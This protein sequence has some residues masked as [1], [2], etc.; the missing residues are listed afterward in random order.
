MIYCVNNSTILTFEYNRYK[1]YM[2]ILPAL[3]D[4]MCVKLI[5]LEADLMK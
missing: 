1:M 4:C 3:L 5:V 2:D